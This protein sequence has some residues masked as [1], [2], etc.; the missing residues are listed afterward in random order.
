MLAAAG[1]AVGG[2][3]GLAWAIAEADTLRQGGAGVVLLL[4][5]LGWIGCG[6][7]VWPTHLLSLVCG[8]SLGWPWGAAVALCTATSAAPLGYAAGKWL[9]GEASRAWASRYPRGAAVLEAVTR[10]SPRRAAWLIALL[11]LS[12]IV[13]YGATN[14]LAAAVAVPGKPFVLGTAL[15]LAPR[16]AVVAGLGAG[17]ESLDLSQP[18]NWTLAA[19]GM[20]ATLLLILTLGWVTRDALRRSAATPPS[21]VEATTSID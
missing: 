11:R 3:L 14:V 12:P 1:P 9:A 2:M 8:W 19:I 17:L 10:A 16:V 5:A 20:I 13:P 4:I 18:T 7:W 15:G 6:L 21:P